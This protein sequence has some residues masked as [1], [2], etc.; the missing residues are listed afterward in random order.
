MTALNVLVLVSLL[1]VAILFWWPSL[2]IVQQRA[3]AVLGY[4]H[5]LSTRFRC[6]FT[7]LLGLFMALWALLRALGSN[8]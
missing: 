3:G 5:Q 1:Y 7:A 4:V 6:R 8:F 2:R